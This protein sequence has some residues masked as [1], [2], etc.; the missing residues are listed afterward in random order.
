MKQLLLVLAFAAAAAAQSTSG[1]IFVAPGGATGSA[2]TEATLQAGGGVEVALPKHFGA[3]AELGALS[4]V[5]SWGD[6]TLGVFSL[7][8]YY[9]FY[10]GR[11]KRID[12]FVA[13]GYTRFFHNGSANLFHFGGGANIWATRHLGA[14][15]ELRDQIDTQYNTIHY[16]GFRLGLAFR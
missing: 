3:G 5:N 12:P 8:G 13:A 2:R 9:H 11:T 4:P 14:K 1:Y 15:V 6:Y 7:S 10:K 16:W